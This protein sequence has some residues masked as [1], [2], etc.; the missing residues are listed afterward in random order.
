M[1]RYRR[2]EIGESIGEGGQGHVFL[3]TDTQNEHEGRF[4]LKR[5]KNVKRKDL[6]EREIKAI[7]QLDHPN[8]LRIIDFDVS[9]DAPFYVAEYCEHGSLAK[10]GA[11]K[12]Q[13]DIQKAGSV[14]VPVAQ[15]LAKA[16]EQGV[17]HRDIKPENILL[18]A[19]GTPVIADFGICHMEG[20]ER[21]TL[22]D[23]AIGAVNYI[24]PE[25]ESGRRWGKPTSK[26]D[27]YSL[28][29]VLYWMLSGGRIFS[30][31]NHRERL[32]TEILNDQSFEHVHMLLDRALIENPAGR[33][34]LN[35]FVM[36]LVQAQS[37][38]EGRYA[39]LR[40]SIKIRCRFCGIGTYAPVKGVGG[41]AVGLHSVQTGTYAIQ[42]NALIC[43]RCGHVELFSAQQSFEWWGK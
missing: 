6:F 21:V 19:D 42:A 30:R 34:E 38:V 27:V 35:G 26:T 40:P 25:M 29:K 12:F 18:R 17:V 13:G 32:L 43:Q 8:I 28:A 1:A 14:L 4:V 31:E 37:L 22:T 41:A 16:H 36:D 23:E 20:A 33:L 11:K 9:T 24:A 39:P 10:I 7:R 2:W 5:L 3:A 15:A